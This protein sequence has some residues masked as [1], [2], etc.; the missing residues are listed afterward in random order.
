MNDCYCGQQP[1]CG[2]DTNERASRELAYWR[3]TA[4]LAEAVLTHGASRELWISWTAA[5]IQPQDPNVVWNAYEAEE[6]RRKEK[7]LEPYIKIEEI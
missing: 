4:K 6:I 1:H 3:M 7:G 5:E 2:H